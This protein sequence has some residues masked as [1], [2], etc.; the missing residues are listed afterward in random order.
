MLTNDLLLVLLYDLILLT[1]DLLVSLQLLLTLEQPFRVFPSL[2]PRVQWL[3]L[4]TQL[5]FVGHLVGVVEFLL[6]LGVLE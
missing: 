1:D 4:V 3:L 6:D 2:R 5:Y